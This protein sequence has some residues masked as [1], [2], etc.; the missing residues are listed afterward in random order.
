MVSTE[1]LNKK[2][3]LFK[4]LRAAKE[5]TADLEKAVIDTYGPR[6]K[7][8]LDAVK[9]GGV[10]KQEGRWFVRGKDAEYEIVRTYCTCYDY[11]LNVVT[12]KV[13]VDMCYHALA[14]S[15]SELLATRRR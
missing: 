4:Q 2:T 11:V 6:G 3:E 10:R 9:G 12:E 7:R 8:A 14:K 5:L 15:I 13:D 1:F